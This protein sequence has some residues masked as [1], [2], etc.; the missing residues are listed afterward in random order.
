MFLNGCQPGVF[1]P[2][3][4]EDVWTEISCWEDGGVAVR[5]GARLGQIH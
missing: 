2:G 1:A 4:L 5:R 3:V